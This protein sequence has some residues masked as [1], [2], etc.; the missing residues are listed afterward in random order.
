MP[1]AFRRQRGNLLRRLNTDRGKDLPYIL[2]TVT[3]EHDI[4]R[5]F[6]HLDALSGD[7]LKN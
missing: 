7:M 1:E 2:G 3:T 4:A 6:A 5:P